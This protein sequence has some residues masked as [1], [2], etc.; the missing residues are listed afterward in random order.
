MDLVLNNGTMV[1]TMK[2]VSKKDVSMV[3]E[4]TNGLMAVVTMECG[5]III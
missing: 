2:V 3:R 1:H 4:F 5:F